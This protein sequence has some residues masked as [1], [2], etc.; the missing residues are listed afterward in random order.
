MVYDICIKYTLDTSWKLSKNRYRVRWNKKGEKMNRVV[1]EVNELGYKVG[2]WY[3]RR[4]YSERFCY[5]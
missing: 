4:K 3:G 2:E 1:A 5:R